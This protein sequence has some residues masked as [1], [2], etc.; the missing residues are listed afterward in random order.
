[1]LKTSW[2]RLIDVLKTF[3]QTSWRCVEDVLKTSYRCLED[4]FADVLK[5]FWRLVEDVSRCFFARRLKTSRRRL[6]DAWPRRMYWSWSR[7]L[8]DVFWRRMTK[9]NIFVLIKTSSED[10]LKTPSSR[11]M[12]AGHFTWYFYDKTYYSLQHWYQFTG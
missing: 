4:L 8:E 2:R 3:L 11:Q 1:M 5:T 12:F 7:R 9:A 10:V 6:E